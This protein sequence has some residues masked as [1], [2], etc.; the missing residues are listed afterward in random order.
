MKDGSYILKKYF[1]DQTGKSSLLMKT[2]SAFI[3]SIILE[4]DKIESDIDVVV[5]AEVYILGRV[6]FG[7]K[8][9]KT[10]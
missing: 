4:K 8:E 3:N 9:D 2:L 1:I 5:L 7:G 10:L 6:I